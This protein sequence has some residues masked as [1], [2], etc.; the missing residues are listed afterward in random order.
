M[1]N[2]QKN[3]IIKIYII[4]G[5]K[6]QDSYLSPLFLSLS[7]HS[8]QKNP[9]GIQTFQSALRGKEMGLFLSLTLDLMANSQDN[10]HS[11]D[12]IWLFLF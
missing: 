3:H 2:Q 12:I 1:G 7:T 8:F 9:V 10:T 5:N 6:S 11:H 4:K